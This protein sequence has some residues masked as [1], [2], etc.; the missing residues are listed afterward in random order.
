LALSSAT[1]AEAKAG[2]LL[3]KLYRKQKSLQAH[4]RAF[5]IFANL[6]FVLVVPRGH[7]IVIPGSGNGAESLF[8]LLPKGFRQTRGQGGNEMF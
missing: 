5:V 4:L 2:L 6:A 3:R 1:V 7:G 8:F